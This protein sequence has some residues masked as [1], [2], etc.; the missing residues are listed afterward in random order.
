MGFK[1]FVNESG[2]HGRELL[3]FRLQSGRAT[4]AENKGGEMKTLLATILTLASF[5]FVGSLDSTSVASA[6]TMGRPQVRIQIGQ[7]RR[8]YRDWRRQRDWDRA[9]GDRI[10]YGR[11]FTRDVQRG[12]RLYRETYQL[13]YLPNGMTQTVLISRYRLN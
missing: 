9:R 10:G 8:H 12:F 11:T 3:A 2:H 4:F 5:A 7:P 1:S 13:R 6:A